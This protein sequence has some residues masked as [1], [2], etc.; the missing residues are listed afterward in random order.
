MKGII[1]AGGSGSRLHPITRGV[2]KQLLPIYDKPM[3][4]YPLSV[5]M[6]AGIR[7]VLII[8]TPEDQSY[9]QRLLGDGSAFGIS[10]EYA[11]QPSPD[12]LA[13]AFIIGE[14]FLAGGPS[15]LVLGDNIFFGQGF[16]PKLRHV[17]ARTDGATVF[18]Y[19]VM[20]PERFGVVEFDEDFRAISIEEKPTHPKSRWAVTGLYFYDSNVVEYAKQVKPSSRGELEITSINQMYMEAGKLNV[21]LLGRGFAWLDTGT[22]DSLIE[23]STFVQTVEKRQGFKIACLEEIAWRNGWLAD[24]DVKRVAQQLAK[25]GYGQYLM[26]LLRAR[27]RQY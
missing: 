22:H 4:Y 1:L 10:L 17:A 20:D 15:C 18:G 27:P 14:S 7:E 2:S 12:G 26:E 19:Q 13:Q 6:L 23:A 25:T 16:S 24:E 3:I 21:E 5:L 9:F 8:T 11:V